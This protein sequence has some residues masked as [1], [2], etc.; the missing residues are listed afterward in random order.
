V[1]LPHRR[2]RVWPLGALLAA[3][4]I[5]VGCRS[6]PAAPLGPPDSYLLF[7]ASSPPA[8]SPGGFP[9]VAAMD[10]HER[11]AAPVA[12]LLE[13]GFAAEALRTVYLAKQL[14]REGS[15]AGR[16]TPEAGRALAADA[17]YI[18]VGIDRVPVGRGLAV[19]RSLRAPQERPSAA[20]LGLPVDVDTDRA[21]VQSLAGRLA[22]YAVHLVASGGT[23]ETAPPP[24]LADG[25]RMAFEV[26]ARE[27]R[28]PPG[29]GGA[30][31]HDAGTATQRSVFAGVREN[32]Y[33]L[34]TTGERP[35]PAAA[36]LTEPGVAAT[37]LYRLAQSRA[38]ARRPAPDVFYAPFTAGRL[39]PGVSPAALLGSFRNFQ[40]K[41][42][43]A[44]GAAV[45]QGRAPRDIIDLVDLYGAAFPQEREEVLRIFLTTTY[46]ATVTPDGVPTSPAEAAR[47]A[48]AL[49]ALR[50]EVLAGRLP[51]RGSH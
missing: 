10:L 15:V 19:S 40:A 36:L 17:L 2:C 14:V 7:A 46:G 32:R 18:V 3:T 22:L 6:D 8:I 29:P 21:L 43:G 23:F 42:L 1:S 11:T 35:L 41:L 39:P 4:V 12:R 31:S 26:I 45:Q 51:L 20:W 28:A 25:Y 50:A 44:W 24:A 49:D 47:A 9:V 38:I 27:W 13:D 5:T 33:V 30:L 37:V 34:T 16:R 48:T